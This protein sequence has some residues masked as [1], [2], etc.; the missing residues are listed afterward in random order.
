MKKL[1]L[2]LGFLC[3]SLNVKITSGPFGATGY[4]VGQGLVSSFFYA[5]VFMQQDK[6]I[7]TLDKVFKS[8][9]YNIMGQFI[10]QF[11]VNRKLDF[12]WFSLTCVSNAL[13]STFLPIITTKVTAII[14]KDEN[15]FESKYSDLI[16][17]DLYDFKFNNIAS[18]S[19]LAGALACRYGTPKLVNYIVKSPWR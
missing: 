13:I 1:F 9:S 17:R 2:F 5:S 14:K 12:S 10:F 8:L 6:Q 4:I 15:V 3:L 11:F 16:E 18:I 19:F 7:V